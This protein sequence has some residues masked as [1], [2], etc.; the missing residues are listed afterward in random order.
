MWLCGVRWVVSEGA[1]VLLVAVSAAVREA[2]HATGA[3]VL[4]CLSHDLVP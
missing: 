4:A 3:E 2:I 1:V